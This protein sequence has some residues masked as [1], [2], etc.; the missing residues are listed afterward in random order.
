M[1]TDNKP[2][3]P[4]TEIAE[5]RVYVVPF[6]DVKKAPKDKRSN[7]AIKILREFIIKHMKSETVLINQEVNEKIWNRGI[8]NP[9][10]KLKVKAIKD[11]EGVVEVVLA[12]E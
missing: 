4:E 9:P 6:R 8:E 11:R 2:K 7:K 5:E 10:N 12:E 3:F 1:S